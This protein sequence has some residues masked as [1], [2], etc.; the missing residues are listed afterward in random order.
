M[1]APDDWADKAAKEII[2]DGLKGRCSVRALALRLRI[3]EQ[4]GVNKGIERFM[5]EKSAA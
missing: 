5:R 3:I 1:S 2:D 4:N